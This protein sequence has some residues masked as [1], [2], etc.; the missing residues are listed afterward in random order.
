MKTLE[1]VSSTIGAKAID[2]PYRP[3][4]RGRHN[5]PVFTG[6]SIGRSQSQ[7][8]A[9]WDVAS[10][11]DLGQSKSDIRDVSAG[12]R[13][14]SRHR[15]RR[16]HGF[17]LIECALA[18]IIVGV[19][20]VASIRLFSA[21]SLESREANHMTAAMLLAGHI[22]EAMT[23]LPFNDPISGRTN[24]GYEAGETLNSFDDVD[25]FDGQTFSPPIDSLRQPITSMGQYSQV[26]SVVPVFPNKL[27]SN[28]NENALEI[29][30]TT[31]TGAV[32][33]RVRVLYQRLPSD[34]PTEVY[35]ASWVRLDN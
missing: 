2:P 34:T 1:T 6:G 24:F 10:S 27:N 16:R 17:T 23:Q 18:M 35:R 21:C 19:G 30:K 5:E 7:R 33:V 28:T 31:Y 26:V 11:I 32:R 4:A 29:N 25:D 13:S 14:T 20:V 9:R 15:S 3:M 8:A 22:R 12:Y